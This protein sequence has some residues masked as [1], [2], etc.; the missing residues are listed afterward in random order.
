[1]RAAVEEGEPGDGGGDE[2]EAAEEGSSLNAHLYY[3]WGRRATL[4][5]SSFLPN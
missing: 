2:E 5:A 4:L 3:Q 1:L